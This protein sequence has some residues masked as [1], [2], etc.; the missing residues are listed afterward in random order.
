M[1]SHRR[2]V[3]ASRFLRSSGSTLHDKNKC[4]PRPATA[5]NQASQAAFR[6][7]PG[8]GN[9]DGLHSLL[10]QLQ[11]QQSFAG[12]NL[13]AGWNLQNNQTFTVIQS[14]LESLPH[15]IFIK[16]ATARYIACNTL[17]A[18][19]LGM[20]AAE[21]IGKNDFDF[22]PAPLAKRF[23]RE[24]S[25]VLG[26]GKSITVPASNP[27]GSTEKNLH[28]VKTP[29]LDRLGQVVGL[30]GVVTNLSESRQN[31]YKLQQFAYEIETLYQDAP[32][33]Y[34]SIDAHG[35]ILRINNT[36][37]RWLDYPRKELI[38]RALTELLSETSRPCFVE[39]FSR[40][41]SSMALSSTRTTTLQLVRRDGCLLP[42]SLSATAVQDDEGNFLSGKLVFEDVSAHDELQRER[43]QQGAL[44]AELR[45]QIIPD[46]LDAMRKLHHLEERLAANP[47]Y[48]GS[49][50][51]S[52][53]AELK[54]QLHK[55]CNQLQLSAG[56][57]SA[58]DEGKL[59]DKEAVSAS[60]T[61]PT[62]PTQIAAAGFSPGQIE[63]RKN[64]CRR[65]KTDN[66]PWH[67]KPPEFDQLTSKINPRLN[68]ADASK[69]RT[70][71]W[72][73]TGMAMETRIE[74]RS[75]KPRRY[76][77]RLSDSR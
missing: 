63:R 15:K 37:L 68:A 4:R 9:Q 53:L 22:Y 27:D 70:A 10:Q 75:G 45:N 62:M 3:S 25:S 24:D 13:L 77:D 35:R 74:R 43:R 44:G 50:P 23:L 49:A 34:L 6:Q 39:H 57:A 76:Q 29:F 48:A 47:A 41:R 1:A 31:Q 33:A 36:A 71:E 52:Q 8:V 54:Q 60:F 66:H 19:A 32:C 11:Q 17:Y 26:S 56:G 38:N 69:L 40:L 20:S 16:D 28:L 67:N 55:S 51:Q 18:Q 7:L 2:L 14:L 64:R 65:R 73:D 72:M 58:L 30:V 61:M 5:L 21:L 12:W 42:V 59:D 46:L